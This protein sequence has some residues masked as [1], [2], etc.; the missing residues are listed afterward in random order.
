MKHVIK[1]QYLENNKT[2]TKYMLNTIFQS[3]ISRLPEHQIW[4][5]KKPIHLYWSKEAPCKFLWKLE[6]RGGSQ[7][8]SV[9]I[10]SASQKNFFDCERFALTQFFGEGRVLA[11][12]PHYYR[13][14]MIIR[15]ATYFGCGILNETTIW[16]ISLWSTL[17]FSIYLF[18]SLRMLTLN[19][20]NKTHRCP[21][22]IFENMHIV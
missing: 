9:Y 17:H 1:F 7:K 16:Q 19:K 20:W 13:G 11:S 8:V 6:K 2:T 18:F 12:R 5:G 10:G 14:A 4:C 21:R 15:N 3:W 22:Y